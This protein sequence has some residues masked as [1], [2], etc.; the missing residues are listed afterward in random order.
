MYMVLVE[1]ASRKDR[2]DFRCP[3]YSRQHFENKKA[4]NIRCVFLQTGIDN[5]DYKDWTLL[6][7]FYPEVEL[8]KIRQ[9]LQV[10]ILCSMNESRTID[11]NS[12]VGTFALS[13]CTG[14]IAIGDRAVHLSHFDPIMLEVQIYHLANFLRDEPAAKIHVAAVANFTQIGGEWIEEIDPMITSV[15]LLKDAAIIGYSDVHSINESALS[16]SIRW[17]GKR[18]LFGEAI[19]L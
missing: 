16:R 9:E 3:V 1:E 8:E 5:P 7:D 12:S 17:N 4:Q 2:L 19:T 10:E 14:I 18:V 6:E 15:A 11:I 13:G